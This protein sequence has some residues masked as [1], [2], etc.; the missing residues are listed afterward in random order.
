VIAVSRLSD[1]LNELSRAQRM[2]QPQI[3]KRS[4]DLGVPLSKG[5]VSRYLSGKHPEKPQHATLDA[6]AQVF[7]VPAEDLEAA[8]T[9]TGHEP[10]EAHASADLLTP[11]QRTAVNEIIRLLAESNKGAAHASQAEDQEDH[12]PDVSGTRDRTPMKSDELRARREAQRAEEIDQ[13]NFGT[14]HKPGDL[15]QGKLQPPPPA[16]RSVAYTPDEASEGITG[17]RE[18]RDRGEENQ[19]HHGR[20]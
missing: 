18:S 6:F 3:V 12:H 14:T 16:K 11:P 1:L 2:N 17:D 15:D 7:G 9:H 4:N 10:F 20:E 8:A 19:D 13:L 5:N